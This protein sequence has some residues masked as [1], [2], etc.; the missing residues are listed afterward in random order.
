MDTSKK[1]FVIALS[2]SF[3]C[4]C[5]RVC[6]AL[7]FS[8]FLGTVTSDEINIRAD[9]TVS[10][11]A[12]YQTRK[13]DYVD[14]IFE[15]YDWY[16]IKLPKKSPSYIKKDLIAPLSERAGKVIKENVNIRMGPSS[17]DPII[18]K[19]HRDEVVTILAVH[20]D[21]YRIEPV[22]NSYGWISKRF[23]QKATVPP[24]V[25]L[26]VPTLPPTQVK[27]VI[28]A[29]APQPIPPNTLTSGSLISVEGIVK[30][31]GKIFKR[32]ATHKLIHQH[33]TIFLL[34]GNKKTLDALIN[35]TV[36]VQGTLITDD[37][38]YPII[39]IEKIE[40]LD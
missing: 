25:Q 28:T 36:K 19:A 10:A 5:M 22:D 12:I 1:L 18:G 33:D 7:E 26:V 24:P 32:V 3:V 13:G 38:R 6:V 27:P 14:V 34:K 31:H 9:S 2:I 39:E 40:A 35:H 4:A 29:V 15:L 30:P 37:T 20:G 21:W 16:K 8:P 17:G 11:P 23:V